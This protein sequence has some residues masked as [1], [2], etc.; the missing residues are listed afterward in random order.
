MW[1]TD[2]SHFIS[3]LTTA[4][5]HVGTLSFIERPSDSPLQLQAFVSNSHPVFR[6]CLVWVPLDVLMEV[7]ICVG[8]FKGFHKLLEAKLLQLK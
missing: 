3:L 7:G 1:T 4:L 2:V 8:Y 5:K 6:K